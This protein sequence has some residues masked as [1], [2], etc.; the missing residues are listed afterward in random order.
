MADKKEKVVMRRADG[1]GVILHR[2][3]VKEFA[4]ANKG[5]TEEAL[6]AEEQDAAPAAADAPAESKQR[7]AAD[8]KA[9][10]APKKN[11]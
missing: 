4:A 7:V 5:Y 11:G 3:D 1:S 10:A 2:A 8:D 9:V 6:P